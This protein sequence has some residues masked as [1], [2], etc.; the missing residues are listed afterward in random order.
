M[1]FYQ[2]LKET[3]QKE[4]AERSPEYKTRLIRWRKAPSVER[5]ER[6]T[7]LA[8]A[9]EL[10][11]KAKQGIIVVRVKIGK[12]LR[13]RIKP[14]NGRKP[15]K[16]AVFISADMSHQGMA[17]QK[18]AR[19]Y[20]N[21]EV[22]NSYWVGEDGQTKYFEVILVDRAHPSANYCLKGRGRSFRGLTSAGRKSRNHHKG[23]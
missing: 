21:C 15:S 20:M 9:R 1:S 13:K 18:A 19:K 14:P 7:N 10:G 5:A 17:E 16:A 23:W 11:Y 4:Y 22:L 3:F 6:P 2:L 12:G 8:R